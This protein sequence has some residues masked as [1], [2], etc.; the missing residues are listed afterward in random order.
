MPRASVAAGVFVALVCTSAA[1]G[2]GISSS[3]SSAS[4]NLRGREQ[5]L[6]IY[7]AP[8]R[9]AAVVASGDGGWIHLGPY[10]AQFLAGQGWHV[11]GFDTKAYLSGFTSGGAT[12]DPK[13]V[14]ADLGAVADYAA[15]DAPGPPVLIG[16]SEGAGLAV[17]AAADD[18]VKA[19]VAGVVGLGLPDTCELGWRLRDSLIYLTKG[20]PREPTFS[21]AEFVARVAPLPLVAIHSTRDEFVAADEVRHV[22]SRARD[23][24]QLWF[25][26]ADNHRFSGN[27]DVFKAKLLEALDWIKERR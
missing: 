18:A 10:V 6:H 21:T 4:I 24:S 22:M 14:P 12:L 3:D 27:A 25:V 13:D 9:P 20:V 23:P 19:R 15:R 26:P 16:V 1:A 11:V 5:T 17:L 8:G 7:G 2:P